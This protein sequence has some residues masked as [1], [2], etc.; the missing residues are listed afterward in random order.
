MVF[1]FSKDLKKSFV[2]H[3]FFNPASFIMGTWSGLLQESNNIFTE[4]FMEINN[5]VGK[6]KYKV[7]T[8][9]KTKT[10]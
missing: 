7:S 8:Q 1:V 2:Y 4:A 6:N 3:S 5:I 10:L 9:F